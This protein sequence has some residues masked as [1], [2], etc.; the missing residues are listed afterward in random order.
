MPNRCGS[1]PK[2][3]DRDVVFLAELLRGGRDVVGGTTADC[4]CPLK[5]EE[6]TFGTLSLDDSI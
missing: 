2:F 4:L 3:E 6:F 5:S 1:V